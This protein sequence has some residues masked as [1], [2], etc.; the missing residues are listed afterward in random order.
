[1]FI[2]EQGDFEKYNKFAKLEEAT[3]PVKKSYGDIRKTTVFISHKHE[4]L[5][6]LKGLI[7]FLENTYNVQ[8]YIDGW[9]KLM[10]DKTS[11]ETARRIKSKIRKCDKFILLATDRAV[12]SKWCNWELGFGDARKFRKNIALFPMKAKGSRDDLYKGNEYLS[13]YPYII[14]ESY[15]GSSASGYYVCS[16]DNCTTIPLEDW[17][18]M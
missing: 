6:D 11:G 10:P 18:I 17:F 1:M 3:E 9:D 14:R 4:D 2:F 16:D 8:A 15:N 5:E 7:G 13:I 12:E